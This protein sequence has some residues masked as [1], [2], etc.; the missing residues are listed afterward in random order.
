MGA[1]AVFGIV[2]IVASPIFHDY[3]DINHFYAGGRTV[4]TPALVDPALHRAWMEV[5]GRG[6][7]GWVYP[8]GAAWLFLPISLWSEEVCFWLNALVMMGCVAVASG[9]AARIYGLDWRVALLMAFAWTPSMGP[10]LAGQNAALALLFAM[11]AI[12]GLRRGG[13]AGDALAGLGVG[14]MLYKPTLALPLLGLLV[15]RLR[16][17]ALVVVAL[18]AAGWYLAGV[19]AAAG[20]WGWPH[21]WL[22]ELNAWYASDTAFNVV[23]QISTTGLLEGYGA[24]ALLTIGVGLGLVGLALPRLIRAP[25]PEAAAG[26][27][28]IGL[29]ASPHALNYDGALM[30]PV[31]LWAVGA[32]RTG[33]AEPWRTRLVVAAC[34]VAPVWMVSNRIGLS[35]LAPLVLA[36]TVIWST[37]LWRSNATDDEPAEV[38]A[39]EAGVL[40]A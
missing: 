15:L 29:A 36:G 28:L 38:R 11:I 13:A 18:A 25:L 9:L 26:A 27:L 39:S 4:G 32:G 2:A 5:H 12:A 20:D 34:V 10:A 33:L 8:A 24:P 19:A 1:L 30:L 22:S 31:L 3:V 35:V 14:L 17:R 23:R 16:W 7:A 6:V 40:P 21:I 37:G